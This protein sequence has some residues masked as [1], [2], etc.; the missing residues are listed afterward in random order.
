MEHFEATIRV[1]E[2][3]EPDTAGARRT[4]EERLAL[5]GF[6]KWQV[7]AVVKEGTAVP[8]RRPLPRERMQPNYLGGRA[9]MLGVIAWSLWLLWLLAG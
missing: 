8:V 9:L 5:G 4:I 6:T 3:V 7:L 1:F 2:L